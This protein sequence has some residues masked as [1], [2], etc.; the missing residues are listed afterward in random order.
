MREY[1]DNLGERIKERRLEVGYSQAKLGEL[2]GLKQTSIADIE[3]SRYEFFEPSIRAISF[4]L[5]SN[6]GID[7]LDN[8]KN[9]DHPLDTVISDLIQ[10]ILEEKLKSPKMREMIQEM[11]NEAV[12]EKLYTAKVS[13]VF[14]EED[15]TKSARPL[16]EEKARDKKLKKI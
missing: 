6:F 4:A 15:T 12:H 2:V 3:N 14:V 8:D 10:N 1:P 5:K 16:V 9:E 11:V 7:W 13:G